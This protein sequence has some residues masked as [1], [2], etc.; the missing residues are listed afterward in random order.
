M[1]QDGIKVLIIDDSTAWSNYLALLLDCEEDM[2]V[3]GS[4]RN[5]DDGL[6]LVKS[7]KPDI[8]ILDIFFSGSE[9]DGLEWIQ[10]IKL[11]SPS[12]IIVAT[13]SKDPNHV[14]KA[15]LS[16]AKDFVA[17]DDYRKIPETIREV[18]NKCSGVY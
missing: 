4:A 17:K 15:L 2:K 9:P 8:V 5:H 10:E 7:L 16:G 11:I 1:E 13:S 12:K 6:N 3:I 18:L 14:E